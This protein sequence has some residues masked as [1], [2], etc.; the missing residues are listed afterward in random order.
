MTNRSG[1]GAPDVADAACNLPEMGPRG[2]GWAALQVVL[3]AA[4]AAGPRGRS[5]RC[6]WTPSVAARS[7]GS[8]RHTPSTR[9]TGERSGIVAYRSCGEWRLAAGA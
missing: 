3:L 2:E 4:M 6:S 9:R 8:A 7:R 1:R 5:R